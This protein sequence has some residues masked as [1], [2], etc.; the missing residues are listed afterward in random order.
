MT[1]NDPIDP[2][3]RPY[4]L[5]DRYIGPGASNNEQIAISTAVC[6]GMLLGSLTLDAGPL[7]LTV[8]TL[9]AAD[10]CGGLVAHL[11]DPASRRAHA[12]GRG[13]VH[14]LLWVSGQ[15]LQFALFVWLC[16]DAEALRLAIVLVLLF[17]GSFVVLMADPLMQRKY[18]LGAVCVSLVIVDATVGLQAQGGWFLP[19]LLS[20]VFIAYLPAPQDAEDRTGAPAEA[21]ASTAPGA[22]GSLPDRRDGD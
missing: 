11:Y 8:L 6:A 22:G 1:P 7:A 10:L 3:A 14:H 19:L 12:P 21:A 2:A 17:A 20:K 13:T 16:R 18:G 5:W 9:L 4:T 15:A